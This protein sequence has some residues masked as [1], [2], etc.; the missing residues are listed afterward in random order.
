MTVVYLA[1]ATTAG[2]LAGRIIG[3]FVF[4]V[5]GLILLI[6]GLQKRSAARKQASIGYQ[7]GYPPPGYPPWAN[8][9]PGYRSP[10]Q[11]GYPPVPPAGGYPMPPPQ[12]PPP[13]SAGTGLIVSGII[14]LVIGALG[15][16]GSTIAVHTRR[17]SHRLPIGDCFT[18]DILTS[19]SNVSPSPCSDPDAVLQYAAKV[20]SH[21]MCPD[22]KRTKS[23]YLS[24]ERDGARICFV[25]N[26]AQGQCYIAEHD[27]RTIEHTN[28][29][30]AGAIRI[31]K[32]IEG[33]SLASDCPGGTRAATY[34]V[35]QRT[36]CTERAGR[37]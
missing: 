7:P 34:R 37:R 20:D 5:L 25:P 30:T 1:D 12:P 36:Y 15:L 13:K 21:G 9:P 35:P 4:P 17:S 18:N 10:D 23:T 32:R 6:T 24:L 28:C 22:G 11:T 29:A 8:H 27:D 2:Y 26:L 3:A 16:V 31:V 19:G 33:S 14:M